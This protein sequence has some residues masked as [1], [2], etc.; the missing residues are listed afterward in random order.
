MRQVQAGDWFGV[1]HLNLSRV[2][3]YRHRGAWPELFSQFTPEILTPELVRRV[4]TVCATFPHWSQDQVYEHLRGQNMVLSH[5]QVRQAIEQR[6]EP[7]RG[8]RLPLLL[9][10]PSVRTP[11]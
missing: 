4:A 3:G 5:R 6:G 1:P 11:E 9:P 2:E 7:A 10:Q 8:A